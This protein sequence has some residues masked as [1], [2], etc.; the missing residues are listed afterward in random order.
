[1]LLSTAYVEQYLKGN[2]WAFEFISS[3][4]KQCGYYTI[5]SGYYFDTMEEAEANWQPSSGSFPY[6]I[7]LPKRISDLSPK[8]QALL[9]KF[10]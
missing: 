7:K 1:M 8:Q 5:A 6:F 9:N 4:M 10:I 2:T 3:V